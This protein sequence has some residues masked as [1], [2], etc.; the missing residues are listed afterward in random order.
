M[1]NFRSQRPL[2]SDYS[3]PHLKN[4]CEIVGVDFVADK[5]KGQLAATFVFTKKQ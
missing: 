1:N 2:S 5:S 4:W 3:I